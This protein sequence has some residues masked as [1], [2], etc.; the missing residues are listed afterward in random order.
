MS[1]SRS[2]NAASFDLRKHKPERLILRIPKWLWLPKWLPVVRGSV[3]FCMPRKNVKILF[4]TSIIAAVFTIALTYYGVCYFGF[5]FFC[6]VIF[7]AIWT[8]IFLKIVLVALPSI[9]IR[10]D[11]SKCRLGFHIITH[12]RNHLLLN[13]SDETFVEKVTLK[14]TRKQLI[15]ILL[16]GFKLCED[17]GRWFKLYAQSPSKYLNDKSAPM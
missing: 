10:K 2:R 5:P 8:V 12:E 16:S 9:F 7:T 4:P 3:A 13:S 17:C 15:P 11:C 1:K 14:Q 6:L